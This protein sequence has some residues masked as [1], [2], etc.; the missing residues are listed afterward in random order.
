MKFVLK[1]Y[2]LFFI[3]IKITYCKYINNVHTFEAGINDA[4]FSIVWQLFLGIV[5]PR[6]LKKKN[7]LGL[8]LEPRSGSPLPVDTGG[9]M[10][11]RFYYNQSKK[12]WVGR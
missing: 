10:L 5:I 8:R 9:G 4:I 3:R 2:W 12:K 6:Y 1:Q 7:F 11:V